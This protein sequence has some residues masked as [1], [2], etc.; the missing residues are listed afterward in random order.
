MV[1]IAILHY[2]VWQE[3]KN[4]YLKMY[5]V[6]NNNHYKVVIYLGVKLEIIPK[7]C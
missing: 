3:K 6:N 2:I 4:I 7:Q 5:L 1:K